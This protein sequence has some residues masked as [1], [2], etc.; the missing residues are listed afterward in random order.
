VGS[1]DLAAA[2]LIAAAARS[3]TR[4]NRGDP[5]EK[6]MPALIRVVVG[7]AALLYATLCFAQ[8]APT[9][10]EPYPTRPVR[11]VVPFAAGG[12][13]DLISRLIAQKLSEGLG[14]QFYVENQGGYAIP[15]NHAPSAAT[16]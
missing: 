5:R 8:N 2:R 6:E 9:G 10:T 4:C 15:C 7:A 3:I 11:I 14:K 16:A 12:P 1:S 13:G